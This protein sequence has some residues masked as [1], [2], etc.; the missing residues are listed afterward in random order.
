MAETKHY[1]SAVHEWD[2]AKRQVNLRK[3]GLDFAD[4]DAFDWEA[5]I[6][7]EGNHHDNRV[8]LPPATSVSAFVLPCTPCAEM[9]CG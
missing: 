3:H 6:V 7:A 9:L 4:M 5:A 1:N 8:G 2:E